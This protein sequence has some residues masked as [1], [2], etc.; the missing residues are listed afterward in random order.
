M[1]ENNR[2]LPLCTLDCFRSQNVQL[3]LK[4]QLKNEVDFGNFDNF[5][6]CTFFKSTNYGPL[7]VVHACSKFQIIMRGPST[8]FFPSKNCFKVVFFTVFQTKQLFWVVYS[9]WNSAVWKFCEV[10]TRIY[11][12]YVQK[13]LGKSLKNYVHYIH[14]FLFSL[15]LGNQ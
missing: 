5:S 9:W 12:L 6:N 4:T 14:F 8:G 13:F 1:W 7:C 11:A 3:L 10:L 15:L 2:L